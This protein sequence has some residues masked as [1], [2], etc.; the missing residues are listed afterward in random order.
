MFTK[1]GLSA[2][3]CKAL[4]DIAISTAGNDTPWALLINKTDNMDDKDFAALLTGLLES[5]KLAC[6]KDPKQTLTLVNY[7][8]KLIT[9]RDVVTHIIGVGSTL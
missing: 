8:A 3:E 6:E 2:R 1:P 5:R 9:I 7:A 4:Q